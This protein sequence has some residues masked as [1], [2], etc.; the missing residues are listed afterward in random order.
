MPEHSTPSAR[1]FTLLV[2]LS[3]Q[4]IV[5]LLIGMAIGYWLGH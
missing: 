4:A 3:A 2:I 5:W 1:G